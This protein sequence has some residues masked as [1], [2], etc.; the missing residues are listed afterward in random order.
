ML[1]DNS[2]DFVKFFLMF[3]V[4]F[5]HVCPASEAEWTPVIRIVGLFVMPLFFFV[6]GFFQSKIYDSKSLLVKFK[7]TIYRIVIPLLVWGG[8]CLPICHEAVSIARYLQ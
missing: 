5:D 6:S 4:I 2:W 1:R 3:F 8:G 7:K